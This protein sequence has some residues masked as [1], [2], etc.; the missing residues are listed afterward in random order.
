M[1]VYLAASL[2][3]QVERKWNRMLAEALKKY[4]PALGV[5]LPQDFKPAGKYNDPGHYGALFRMCIDG[6]DAADA[7]LAVLDGAEVDSGVAWEVGYA[8]ARGKPVIGLRTDFRPG[9]EHGLNIMLSRSC[10]FLIREFSFQEDVE[11]LAKAIARRVKKIRL[12]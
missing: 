9:A 7:V 4:M 5:V 8:Y 2:F 12:D 10:R 3:S 1:K 11:T 6:I